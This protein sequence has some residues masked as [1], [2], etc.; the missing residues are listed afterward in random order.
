MGKKILR[1]FVLYCLNNKNCCLNTPTK[2]PL[3]FKSGPM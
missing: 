3:G 2:H 1:K